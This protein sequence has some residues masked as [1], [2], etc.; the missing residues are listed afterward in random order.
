MEPAG[1][2]IDGAPDGIA[3]GRLDAPAA[4]PPH[5]RFDV[6][7]VPVSAID[8]EKAITV[9]EGWVRDDARAFVCVTGVH[10]VI[11]CRDDPE[12][13]AIHR[14][15]DMVTPDGMP[16]VWWA[17]HL[18]R[19]SVGRV[20]GPDLMA[21]ICGRADLNPLK[22]F[23]YGGGGGV[24]EALRVA[25]IAGNPGLR[26]VGTFEPPFR[27]LSEGEAESIAREINEKKPDIVWIGLGTPKQER[28]MAAFR[29][30][31]DAPVLI[32]VGAAFDFLAGRQR[33][34]P[35]WVQRNG[36]EWAYRLIHEP[37][38]LWRRYMNIVPRFVLLMGRE[39]MRRRR[40]SVR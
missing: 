3:A 22:H 7:G 21:A 20:Y 31:L 4:A 5:E 19:A 9:I 15:A 1:V 35:K 34:A 36:I 29:S 23:F 32:G 39:S 28:W 14:R 12:L 8:L 33:Q 13:L 10:G 11:E 30:K 38:R 24:A 2:V 6:L 40:A 26:V 18:G 25:C 17:H 27:P 16:L 37:R